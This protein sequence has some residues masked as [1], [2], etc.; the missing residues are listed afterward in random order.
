MRQAPPTRASA[1]I[2]CGEASQIWRITGFLYFCLLNVM[3]SPELHIG[4][5]RCSKAV[6]TFET[7]FTE[8]STGKVYQGEY[9]FV[10]D[11]DKHIFLPEGQEGV[12]SVA[13]VTIG[14]GFHWER[15]T[16]QRF[17]GG[18]IL[19]PAGGDE[20]W[21]INRVD[22]EEY[23]K[24]V[25]ASEMNPSAP[26][27]FLEAHA[28]ISR[29]WAYAMLQR[30]HS[31]PEAEP[32]RPVEDDDMIVRW[33]DRADHTL[34]D[35]CADDHCQR[36]QGIPGD[37]AQRAAQAV[38]NTRG[39]VLTYHGELCDARFSK[40]CGGVFEEFETC[41]GKEEHPYLAPGRD[42][43]EVDQFPD[44]THENNAEEWMM[45]SPKAFCNTRDTAALAT[46]LKDYDLETTDF[47]RWTRDYTQQ[48]ISDLVSRYSPRPLGRILNL[49]PIERGPS[50]RIK[51]LKIK[52]TLGEITIG[53]ELEIRRWLAPTHLYSSAFIVERRGV[54]DDGVPAGFRLR[55]AGWG[56][57]VGLCQIGAAMMSLQGYCA[58]DILLHY[59]R[60]SKLE[61]LW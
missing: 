58:Q 59:Y 48:E 3:K 19:L 49:E 41:W 39:T 61:K 12:F 22:I 2:F 6:I 20:L 34:F 38:E 35:L 42:Y 50:G 5:Q 25:I 54:A 40:C 21:V 45:T 8:Q 60:G 17:T 31:D 56:H 53:K 9:E 32:E 36:Y 30:R 16:R 43:K 47:Y 15:N 23:L 52:G 57:G 55:G 51:L 11:G 18:V 27:A 44:L 7:P 33:H 13:G 29:S 24:S 26:E 14:I 4:L 10:P 37:N 28:I 1:S 46:V